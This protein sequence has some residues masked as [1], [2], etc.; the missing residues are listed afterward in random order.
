[1]LKKFVKNY[2]GNDDTFLTRLSL[3]IKLAGKVVDP[4]DEI[5]V[6]EFEDGIIAFTV[7]FYH[8][9]IVYIYIRDTKELIWMRERKRFDIRRYSNVELD[10]ITDLPMLVGIEEGE[11]I[12]RFDIFPRMPLKSANTIYKNS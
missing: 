7:S 2:R 4:I 3:F 12:G 9:I 10:Q 11:I 6:Y 8:Y 1:M 5:P